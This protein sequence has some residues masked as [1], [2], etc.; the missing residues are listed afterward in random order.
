T[1]G[2][3]QHNRAGRDA[4]KLYPDKLAAH[5]E[6]GPLAPV[7]LLAGDEPLQLGEAADAVR[8][9]TRREGYASREVFFVERG[10]DWQ[11]L[12][13]AGESLSLFAERRL[14]ELRLP[15]GKPGDVGAKM[16]Q[17]MAARPP[18]D[19]VLLVI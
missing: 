14:L 19:T 18:Q 4:V 10:F 6:H 17:E 9:A 2:G 16:L 13:A 12:R 1:G 7:Y 11:A 15:G 8:A 5:L 3:C